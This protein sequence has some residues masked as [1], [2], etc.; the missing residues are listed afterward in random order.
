MPLLVTALLSVA[1]GVVGHGIYF[2][3]RER[4]GFGDRDSLLLAIATFLLYVPGALLAGPAARR[5][6]A[7]VVMHLANLV[8]M[9]AVLL[10]GSEPPVWGLWLGAAVYNGAAGVVW[11]I[12]EGYVARGEADIHR[13][14]G[15]FNLTWSVTLAPAL[16]LVAAI[17]HDL[18]L[19]FGVL[20]AFHLALGVALQ[21][22]PPNPV[23]P[24]AHAD[25]AAVPAHYPGLL[26]R[27]RTL[28]PVSYLLLYTLSPLL[29]G[30]WAA[31]GVGG[32]VAAALS[33]TWMLARFGLF[34]LFTRNG[35]WRGRVA[36]LVVGVTGLVAGFALT[37]LGGS[38]PALLAGLLLF[39]AGHG[40]VYFCALYYGLTVGKGE[41][42][43]GG[44]HEA[45]IGMGYLAGP[46]L[47]LLGLATGVPPVHAVGALATVGVVAGLWP[48]RG[49]TRPGTG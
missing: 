23:G 33:S 43:S 38:V 44:A 16:W 48:R 19:T 28:L 11:P 30:R 47:G 10:L 45:I 42:D 27:S 7:R 4:Y 26:R 5:H 35:A 3:T 49:V 14:I 9:G 12:L 15:R 36:T 24:H 32:S 13:A 40:A 29:P 31:L 46:A 41:V 37:L 2:L 20:F 39:G 34:L 1:G 22:L 25:A 6:G 17:G 8:S 21:R 18:R